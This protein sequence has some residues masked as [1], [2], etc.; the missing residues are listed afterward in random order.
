VYPK[1]GTLVSDNPYVVLSAEWVDAAKKKAAADFLAFVTQPA[2][3]KRFT[4]AAFRDAAGHPGAAL[5]MDNGALPD[6]QIVVIDAPPPAVLDQVAR[7]WQ[8]LR[9]RARVLLVLD[10]SNSMSSPV[11][12]GGGSKL[13]LAKQA[14][15][16]A[17]TQLA[18]DD[19]LG[20]WTF[21][22]PV[23]GE[24]R[25]YRQLVP[26]GRVS[27]VLPAYKAKIDAL[28]P[29]GGTA[30][31]TTTREAVR[32]VQR[33]FD[34]DR[35]NAVV[36]L[37]DGKNEYPADN[38]L[39]RLLTDIGGEDIDTSVRVFPIAYGT[40]ADLDILKRIA[41]S[42]RAAAY[43]ASDPASITNVLTAVLSNF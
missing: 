14:A 30:L 24:S 10:T 5:T 22:T 15:I 32:A 38:N 1:E 28:V 16:Q 18:A 27:A 6:K 7:S 2:Q 23:A 3:Q 25:P 40:S 34:H 31:Y 21:S 11:P 39:D 33:S 36:L 8:A 26:T 19:E 41:A 12:G 9:K 29:D 42:S 43:D 13:D 4:D 37:T 35:I 17:T 20:L